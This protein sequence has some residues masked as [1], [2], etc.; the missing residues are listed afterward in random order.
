MFWTGLHSFQLRDPKL[1]GIS[2]LWMFPVYGSAAF[3]APMMQKLKGLR[4]WKRGLIYMT[5]IY[6]GEFLS[7]SFL[8]KRE[9][10]PWDYSRSRWQVGEIVR[11]DY[12]PAWFLLGL[13]FEQLLV[14]ASDGRDGD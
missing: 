9:M 12:A 8:K 5:F 13:L 1:T 4:L 3:L 11:L 6:L 2:S 10:C 14:R 7:G